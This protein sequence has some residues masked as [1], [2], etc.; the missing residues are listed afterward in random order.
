MVCNHSDGEHL[1]HEDSRMISLDLQAPETCPSFTK[2]LHPQ[3]FLKQT[4]TTETLPD[5]R[6][7]L[8]NLWMTQLH[9]SSGIRDLTFKTDP[10][11]PFITSFPLVGNAYSYLSLEGSKSSY[12][13]ERHAGSREF[14]VGRR[15]VISRRK[16]LRGNRFSPAS[17]KEPI[18]LF[19]KK[20]ETSL[21]LGHLGGSAGGRR[22]VWGGKDDSVC[23]TSLSLWDYSQ[24]LGNM[25][26]EFMPK[27]WKFRSKSH[28][29]KWMFS[30]AVL[31]SA[32]NG[33][34]ALWDST[35]QILSLEFKDEM[36]P[37]NQL[38]T[39]GYGNSHLIC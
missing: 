1:R 31:F 32:A 34:C 3:N 36:D 22:V 4:Q 24:T 10:A 14:W 29:P 13:L 20:T 21:S 2:A 17:A 11:D 19:D 23:Q 33:C 25:M 15:L 8:R 30:R 12:S 5:F 37:L 35:C 38:I 27:E 16:G 7:M 28:Q 39:H 9:G 26:R 6:T 18:K